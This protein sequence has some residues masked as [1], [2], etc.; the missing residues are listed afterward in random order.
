MKPLVLSAI[1]LFLS[2]VTCQAQLTEK[3][4]PDRPDQTETPFVVP[5][6]Y[7]QA[8]AGFNAASYRDGVDEIVHPTGLLKYGLFKKLELRL[9]GNFLSRREPLIP[10][11][12]TST[13]LPPVEFGT[14][15]ALWEE[16]GALPKTSFMAQVGIPFIASKEFHSEPA[17]YSARLAMQ[18]TLSKVVNLS[19]NIGVEG[20]GNDET[21]FIYTFS[22]GFDMGD[23]WHSFIEL[24]GDFSGGNSDHSLDGGL[25]FTLTA[26][27]Q[28]DLSG[29]FGLGN[30]PVKHFL[31]AGFS[32]RLPSKKH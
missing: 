21:S 9:E 24:F 6:R 25:A 2:A 10:Q 26:N 28:I 29:G 15:I 20:G 4:V 17:P 12:K 19:Y 14:K 30:A 7:F 27:T 1:A 16:R 8:E 31:A 11:P 32:F 13:L 23:K 18:N 3:I 22:T 5:H